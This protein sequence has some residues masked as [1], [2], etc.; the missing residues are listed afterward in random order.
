MLNLAGASYDFGNVLFAVLQE[1]EHKRRAL[2]PNEAGAR[3][4]EIARAKLAE[5]HESY[6]ECGGTETYWEDLERE[7]IETTLPQYVPAAVEQNRLEKSNYDIWRQG[8]LAARLLFGLLGLIIGGLIIAS[9]FIPIVEDAFAFF[10]AAGGFLYPEIKKTYSDFRHSRTLNR[11]IAQAEAYQ[12]DQRLHY[13]SDAR[14]QE[15]LDAVT[16]PPV[17]ISRGQ[18]T[19]GGEGTGNPAPRHRDR[20]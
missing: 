12:K 16:A 20:S 11:L 10:L 6:A 8:D 15:E 18:K 1:C 5:I 2:L 7:V 9:P 14:L 19:A 17:Q 13:M 4:R 3:L